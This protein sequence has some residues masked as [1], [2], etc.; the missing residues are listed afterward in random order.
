MMN[1]FSNRYQGNI[2]HQNL[3]A[4][5]KL[6][7]ETDY[8]ANDKNLEELKINKKENFEH[9]IVFCGKGLTENLCNQ[10]NFLASSFINNNSILIG[11]TDR[12]DLKNFKFHKNVHQIP[13][14]TIEK[15]IPVGYMSE[16]YLFCELKS[17]NLYLKNFKKKYKHFT[18]M[19]KDIYL[20]VSD[21]INYLS[22]VPSLT[23]KYS[24]ISTDQSTNLLR[25]F[26]ISDQ[27]FTIPLSALNS[28]PYRV[29]PNKRKAFWWDYR[30]IQPHEIY[31][32]DH[33][34]E[35]WIWKNIIMNSKQ[36][37]DLNC[38]FEAY[39][40]F[41]EKNLLIITTRQIGYTWNR[42]NTTN[43]QNWVRY[44]PNGEGLFSSTK[45]LRSFF[46]YSSYLSP[47]YKNKYIVSYFKL[48]KTIF[49]IKKLLKF[50]F[51]FPIF[52]INY[53]FLK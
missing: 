13:L 7:I 50:I 23:K 12:G 19:R 9:V 37:I 3:Q 11:I 14:F 27:F 44:V 52:F 22:L 2:L 4:K 5:D 18:R 51:K 8:F 10:L 39:L 6:I 46:S 45:P 1:H 42:F 26:C 38:N 40:S 43:L 15:N 34:M 21:F 33:Q 16:N 28:I 24:Y 41:L 48:L 20:F 17:I 53:I 35:Q 32:N 31:K 29:R 49:F 25:K 30:H 47:V 36:S